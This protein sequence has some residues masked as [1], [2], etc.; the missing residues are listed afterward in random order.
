MVA[1]WRLK[2]ATPVTKAT[3]VIPGIGGLLALR[4]L[5]ADLVDQQGEGAIRPGLPLHGE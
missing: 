1:T 4:R 5:R 3:A 2:Q